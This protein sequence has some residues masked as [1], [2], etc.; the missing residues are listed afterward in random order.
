MCHYITAVLPKDAPIDGFKEL[1]HEHSRGF[2]PISNDHVQIQLRRGDV[3]VSTTRGMC[4]CGTCLGSEADSQS[5][6]ASRIE[7]EVEKLRSKGWS[8]AKIRRWRDQKQANRDRLED[9]RN[10]RLKGGSLD[11]DQWMTLIRDVVETRKA[12]RFG[13]LLHWY[14]S[15]PSSERISI[16]ERKTVALEDLS[17]EVLLT[18]SEDVLYEFVKTV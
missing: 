18:M 6:P 15:N 5:S 10:K 9:E 1:F 12:G 8:E 4:D 11:A 13:L 14:R 16:A 2:E 17:V 7:R 3:Y